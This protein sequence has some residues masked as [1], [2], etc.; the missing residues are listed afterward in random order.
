MA[1]GSAMGARRVPF[2]GL[3]TFFLLSGCAAVQVGGDVVALEESIS[4]LPG[5]CLP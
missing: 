3:L 5:N 4:F 2:L 1:F